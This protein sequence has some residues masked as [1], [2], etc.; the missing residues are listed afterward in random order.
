MQ[1][2][3]HNIE[4]KM[5]EIIKPLKGD[6][7]GNYALHFHLSRLQEAFKSDF[8]QRIAVNVLNDIFRGLDG[9]ILVGKDG[10]I[11]VIY[12]GDNK[13][14]LDKAIFQ[15]RYLFVDDPLANHPNG[16]ENEEFCTLY[17]LA[18]QWRAFHRLCSDK[19]A[20]IK[21]NNIAAK[22]VKMDAMDLGKRMNPMRLADVVSELDEI[23]L[24]YALRK[25][26]IC[27]IKPKG[28]IRAVYNE[29][30]VNIGHLRKLLSTDIEL[31]GNKWLFGYLTEQL[32][33]MVL[34]IL[35]RQAKLY[36]EKPVSI[37]LNVQTLFTQEFQD[38][39]RLVQR[40]YKVSVVVEVQV[41]DVFM[42]MNA[43]IEGRK[44]VQDLGCKICIDGLNNDSFVQVSRQKLGFDLAKLKWNADMVGDLRSKDNQELIDAVKTCGENRMILCRCDS[45]HAI[46]YGH[47]LGISLF[48]GRHSDQIVDPDSVIIN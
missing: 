14:L 48:Q 4:A 11:F 2:V 17:V 5:M 25:Q 15:L 20:F 35:P 29:I 1:I 10:D 22:Q 9:T 28:K 34:D 43:F 24:E 6:I 21:Q 40:R 12:H 7:G 45:E 27:A 39:C 13:Y 18:F 3:S 30:Y 19:L 23:D 32:D 33:L 42:D 16:D 26:P 37:N 44:I 41:F 31:T 47:A 46:G 36:L 8:Q 38:F